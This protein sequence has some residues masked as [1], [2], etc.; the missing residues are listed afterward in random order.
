VTVNNPAPGGG[1][2]NVQFFE[3]RKS[4]LASS[5]TQSTFAVGSFPVSLAS[6]DLRGNGILDLITGGLSFTVSVA[7]GIGDGTFQPASSY[8]VAGGTFGLAVADFNGDG[9]PDLADVSEAVNAVSILLGNGDGTFQPYQSFPTGSFPI[10]I[11][12]GDFNADGRVD[13]AISLSLGEVAI[14]LGNGD[15]TFQIPNE[16]TAGFEGGTSILT[17]D[18]NQDGF[19]DLAVCEQQDGAVSIL[20]GN[21]DGTFQTAVEYATALDPVSIVTGDFNGDGNL[22]L[23]SSTSG[24]STVAGLLGNGDGSFQRQDY[25]AVGQE[26]IG[27]AF[28]DFNA[29]GLLDFSVVNASDNTVSVLLQ[30]TAVLSRTFVDFG[31]VSLGK[32]AKATVTL[33]NIGTRSFNISRITLTGNDKQYFGETNNCGSTLAP[34]ANCAFSLQ[35]KPTATRQYNAIVQLSDSASSQVQ[36]IQLTGR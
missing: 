18:F 31:L 7:L 19:L 22:D 3:I 16:V 29:D 30:G 32:T 33:T 13:L 21:G 28:G 6:A 8:P 11:T 4:F 9:R 35:F 20:L 15:G 1:I 34:G 14:L 24:G 5:F 26:P 25:F 10:S 2:S 12:T 23:I 27:I 17:G 36:N